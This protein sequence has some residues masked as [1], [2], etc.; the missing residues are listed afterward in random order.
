MVVEEELVL[1]VESSNVT[2][3]AAS[4][5][6][7][8]DMVG[9]NKA[10]C[11]RMRCRAAGWLAANGEPGGSNFKGGEATCVVTHPS[12]AASTDDCGQLEGGTIDMGSAHGKAVPCEWP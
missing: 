12:W 11:A 3:D 7:L 1:V 9:G 5:S 10:A 2:R 4:A 6:H 8:C